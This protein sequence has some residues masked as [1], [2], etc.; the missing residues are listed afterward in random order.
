MALE[1]IPIKREES[2]EDYFERII[3]RIDNSN[4]K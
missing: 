2:F 3:R 1:T 4:R